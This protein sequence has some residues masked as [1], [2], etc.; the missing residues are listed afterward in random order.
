[1]VMAAQFLAGTVSRVGAVLNDTTLPLAERFRALFTLR[2]IGGEDAIAQIAACFRDDSALLKHECAYCLGQMADTR[3][4]PFLRSVLQD[5]AENEM[6]RHEAAEALGAIGDASQLG[7]LEQY[8][9]DHVSVVA[10]TCRIA[11]DKISRLNERDG[12][13]S[14]PYLSIDPAPPAEQGGLREWST[15]LT[16]TS[17]SLYRRYQALFS[18]RNNSGHEAV[19]IITAAMSDTNPLFK[20]ELAYVL[21]QMQHSSAV[22]GLTERLAD[23]NE[24]PMVRHE[25]AEALGS[26]ATEQCLSVLQEYLHD[27]EQVVR[28]SCEVALD[29]YQ[30]EHSTDLQYANT[31]AAVNQ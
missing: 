27:K 24:H 10:D 7:I 4:I 16:D 9:G 12:S 1:M 18:L 15:W 25:C 17:L 28:E 23:Y 14:G 11:V 3:A 2:G 13:T 20:H 26:I 5:H 19:A 31:V 29:M 22:S 6:V 30:H 21:G 8:C